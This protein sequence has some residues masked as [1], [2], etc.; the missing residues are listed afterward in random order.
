ML[1]TMWNIAIAGVVGGDAPRPART[2]VLYLGR[3]GGDD[4]GDRR[5]RKRVP[6]SACDNDT[7]AVDI[8]TIL[9]SACRSGL[10]GRT[11]HDH[12]SGW[13]LLEAP[14]RR[15]GAGSGLVGWSEL[16]A[17]GPVLARNLVDH[18]PYTV[19]AL[20]GSAA[21]FDEH[22]GEPLGQLRLLLGGAA[23]EHLNSDQRHESY[24][25]RFR[26]HH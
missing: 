6:G 1:A 12:G 25:S 14:I 10:R 13:S 16:A 8:E 26:R 9:S 20:A 22:F 23:G 2:C 3:S 24:G 21:G 17:L 18:D 5:S 19:G 7:P 15:E 11:V 4:G